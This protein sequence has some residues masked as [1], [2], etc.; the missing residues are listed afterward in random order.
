MYVCLLVVWCVCLHVDIYLLIIC[1]ICD[2]LWENQ[3]FRAKI[4][5]E[6]I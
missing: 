3:T 5:I 4:E 6:I 2:R 1:S